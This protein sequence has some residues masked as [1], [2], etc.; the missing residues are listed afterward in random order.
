MKYLRTTVVSL[1]AGALLLGVAGCGASSHDGA[2]GS[3]ALNAGSVSSQAYDIKPLLHPE[4]KYLGMAADGVPQSLKPVDAFAETASKKPNLV[5]YF[6]AW[7]TDFNSQQAKDI[8]AKGAMP[9]INWEPFNTS[10]AD[11]AAGKS[12]GYIR[13]YAK[14]VR[15]LNIPVGLTFG[16]EMNGDWYPWGASKSTAK[17][18]VAAW[19]HVH[20]LF[21]DQK[22]TNVIWTWSAN[23]ITP[24]PDVK[25]KPYWPGDDYV[26]WV[27][28]VGYY[29]RNGPHTFNTLYGPTMDQIRTFTKKPFIIPETAAEPGARQQADINDLFQGV[30]AHNDVVGLIWFNLNKESDWRIDSGPQTEHSFRTNAANDAFG[31]DPSGLH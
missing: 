31:F 8:W 18:F 27:G 17:D 4:K 9:F 3:A 19:K 29:V 15:E 21:Q 24:A 1:A 10:L 25:L 5:T 2:D 26:D 13:Q 23:N 6:V 28:V 20:D 16:H 30:A 7:G 14:A 12:D 11:I 22:A